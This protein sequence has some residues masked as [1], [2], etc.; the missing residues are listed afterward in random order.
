MSLI[1][2][3]CDNSILFS[4]L[5][6]FSCVTNRSGD[7]FY[8][9]N[10][11]PYFHRFH[12]NHGVH[13]VRSGNGNGIQVIFF[14][15]L[16]SLYLFALGWALKDAEDLWSSTSHKA[17]VFSELTPLTSTTPFPPTPTHPKLSKS[18]GGTCPTPPNTNLGTIEKTDAAKVLFRRNF[19]RLEPPS[20]LLPTILITG[21]LCDLI[22]NINRP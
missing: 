4:K 8:G 7:W 15:S 6:Q 16:K 12:S 1:A 11:N 3:L 13:M 14:I 9:V 20:N 22:V 2:H 10:M 18:L 17:M 5:P 21:I 19:L